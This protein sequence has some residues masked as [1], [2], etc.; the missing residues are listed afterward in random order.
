M[1]NK[2]EDGREI[3]NVVYTDNNG[4][5]VTSEKQYTKFPYDVE[6][7]TFLE[8]GHEMLTISNPFSG[9]EYELTPVEESVYSMIMGSQLMPGYEQN[10]KLIKIVRDGLTWFRDNNAKAYMALLD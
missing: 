5:K 10:D 7:V 1:I 2:N 4:T 6:T 9:A 8:E 3:Y